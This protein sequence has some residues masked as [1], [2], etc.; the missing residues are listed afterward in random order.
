[1]PPRNHFPLPDDLSPS[2][3]RCV[4]FKLPDDPQWENLF[5][6]SIDQLQLWN[7]YERS[8]GG[9]GKTVA[10]VWKGVIDLAQ[11][12]NCGCPCFDWNLANAVIGD[13]AYTVNG[14]GFAQETIFGSGCGFSQ[15]IHGASVIAQ[16]GTSFYFGA[17][18]RDA[19]GFNVGGPLAIVRIKTLT[20]DNAQSIDLTWEDCEGTHHSVHTASS[21]LAQADVVAKWFCVVNSNPFSYYVEI[22]DN[23]ICREP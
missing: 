8:T 2:V 19:D 12:S 6:G 10:D 3:F 13:C 1:M 17:A 11:A 18:G 22:K 4:Q 9:K 20:F 5:W 15:I 21:Q 7:S 23:L 16:D 14:N